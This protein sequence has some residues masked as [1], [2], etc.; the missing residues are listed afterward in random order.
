MNVRPQLGH[1]QDGSRGWRP[2]AGSTGSFPNCSPPTPHVKQVRRKEGSVEFG[3]RRAK[4]HNTE[5]WLRRG[6]KSLFALA[7]TLCM[8]KD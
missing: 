6:A 8:D 2:S 1:V 7:H 5:P 4:Q 3:A